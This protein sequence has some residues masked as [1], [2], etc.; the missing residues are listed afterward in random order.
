MRIREAQKHTDPEHCFYIMQMLVK[1]PKNKHRTCFQW[2]NEFFVRLYCISVERGAKNALRC[3]KIHQ[4]YLNEVPDGA[5]LSSCSEHL[6]KAAQNLYGP[7]Q[8]RRWADFSK[9][10]RASPFN[11]GLLLGTGV[12]LSTIY[13]W[14]VP[15]RWI[16]SGK[17]TAM[18]SL[19]GGGGGVSRIFL[20]GHISRIK[21]ATMGYHYK[22]LQY[23]V[24]W[25]LK[26]TNVT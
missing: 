3:W 7:S 17:W 22:C 10:L 26:N 11:G 6:C 12:P 4:G 1:R 23:S 13:L 20:I 19:L 25:S 24:M 21:G 16:Y 5:K 15:L 14:T 8:D 18:Q 2:N 9:N